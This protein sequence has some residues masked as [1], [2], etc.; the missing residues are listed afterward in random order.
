MMN[1]QFGNIQP[2]QNGQG[3]PTLETS[4]EDEKLHSFWV[5]KIQELHS[6]RV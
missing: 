3:K 5:E 4:G 6:L 2:A 1:P